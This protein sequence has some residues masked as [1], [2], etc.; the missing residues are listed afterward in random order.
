MT[1]TLDDIY[2][3]LSDILLILKETNNNRLEIIEIDESPENDLPSELQLDKFENVIV[4][5]IDVGIIETD[6]VL[7][8]KGKV[9]LSWKE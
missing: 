7:T 8:G 4:K 5:S 9:K 3:I 2:E 1:K 6:S